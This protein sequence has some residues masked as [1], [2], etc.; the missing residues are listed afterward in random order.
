MFIG[1][2]RYRRMQKKLEASIVEKQNKINSLESEKL[3]LKQEND[4][5]REAV[6]PLRVAKDQAL[7]QVEELDAKV[8]RLEK[9]WM[10]K[11]IE[12]EKVKKKFS[13]QYNILKEVEGPVRELMAIVNNFRE[14]KN[15]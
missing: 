15:D 1:R 5:L 13:G 7:R 8:K 2:A 9:S 3:S 4:E 12:Q 14:Q 10:E 11:D 6:E